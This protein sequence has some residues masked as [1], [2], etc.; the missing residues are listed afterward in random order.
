MYQKGFLPALCLIILP[1]LFLTQPA[2]CISAKKILSKV[3]E[4]YQGLTDFQANF[5]QAVY[6]DSSDTAAYVAAGVLWV[7]KPNK[8]RLQLEH[9]TSISDGDTLWTYVPGNQQVLVDQADTT[10][11]PTRPDQLFLTYFQE[12]EAKLVG[13]EQVAGMNCYHLRLCPREKGTISWLQVWVDERN[14]LA[15]RL[16]MADTGGMV[17]DYRFAEIE[18]N[19]GLADSIF[20]FQAPPDVDVIDMRW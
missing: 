3:E 9:Q 20:V 2:E 19:S 10:G 13:T 17:T 6:I 1:L 5:H 14:W 7:K 16:Q 4:R 12:A 18:I 8:F 11:G 15:R